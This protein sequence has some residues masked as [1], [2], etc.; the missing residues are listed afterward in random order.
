MTPSPEGSPREV[1]TEVT[2]DSGE[3]RMTF[4]MTVPTGPMRLSDLLPLA[5]SL[6]DAVVGE[7]IKGVEEA[8]EKISCKAGCGA[9]CRHLVAI[10]EVE[11]RQLRAVVE[12]L[13]EPRRSAVRAR[14]A[15]ARRRFE[16]AGLLPQLQR[17]EELTDPEYA[18][19]AEAYFAEHVACPFL[20][21][22]SCSIHP[23]RP[24]T[25][26]EYLV[27]S[28][29]ENCARPTAENIRRVKIPLPVL[30]AIARCQVPPSVHMVERWVP[31][32]LAL[33]WAAAHR[34]DPPPQPG[35]ELLRD[36][37]EC[38]AG[39]EGSSSVIPR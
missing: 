39:K 31:L 36:F 1:T 38:L 7:A 3:W 13:P 24:I 28:P 17:P 25:C 6:S 37:V 10:S 35:P 33:D 20:E 21:E 32:V 29:A 11:A 27:T 18:A 16:Q 5:R 12:G 4:R 19:L 15:D 2:L 8:G 30:N 23:E 22:E 9:C 26:R 14:F 34:E